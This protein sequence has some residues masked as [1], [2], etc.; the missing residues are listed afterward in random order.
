MDSTQLYLTI[1]VADVLSWYGKR[2][3]H[4]GYMYFSPFRDEAAPSM[5]VTVNPSD[6]TWVWAD[7]GG[8]PSGGRKADG[9]GILHMICR[10]EGM[11][12]S[13]EE[14]KRRAMDVLRSIAESRGISVIREESRTERRRASKPAG[15][16]IDSV[17]RHFSR[18]NLVSYLSVNRGIPEEVFG[19]YCSQVTYHPLSDSSRQFT[20]IGFPNNAG[21]WTL[22]GTG[23]PARS[24][25]NYLSGISTF[26]SEGGHSSEEVP[27]S[28][29]CVL[30][31]GFIDFLSWLSWRGDVRP[32]MDVCVLNS[33][34]NLVRARSW[35][36]AHKVV[37]SFFDNDKAGDVATQ[38]LET[39]CRESGK[40]FRDGRSAY[41]GYDDVN[42]AWCAELEK[43]FALSKEGGK[44]NGIRI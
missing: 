37:R 12:P 4:R 13:M 18:K 33:T 41:A 20:V 11:D 42:D 14:S 6:G 3:D 25:K 29:R 19:R 22:R 43:R 35:V 39:L 24:K 2:V 40:D 34:S 32:G 21:G 10:M 26:N 9:G 17:S 8:T 23:A 44:S 5:R 1:P 30:F 7:F 15:I 28:D 27:T 36:L 16:G 31:E 38:W